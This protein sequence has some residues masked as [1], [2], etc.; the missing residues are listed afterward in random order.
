MNGRLYL[1]WYP[2]FQNL[3]GLLFNFL[4]EKKLHFNFFSAVFHFKR[5]GSG[6]GK[7]SREGVKHCFIFCRWCFCIN[8]WK[9]DFDEVLALQMRA[10][11]V[12]EISDRLVICNV[13]FSVADHACDLVL[14]TK[15]QVLR[16]HK[17][18]MVDKP[19]RNLSLLS[20]TNMFCFKHWCGIQSYDHIYMFHTF[21]LLAMALAL[22]SN[23]STC[24]LCKNPV[25]I[26]WSYQ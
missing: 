4:A 23:S 6:T 22:S 7:H 9:G 1:N 21:Y 24:N 19:L 17:K 3:L 16:F 8:P 15:A 25:N 12:G 10:F 13:Y 18:K 20:R 11:F 14:E 26:I 5:R 2:F